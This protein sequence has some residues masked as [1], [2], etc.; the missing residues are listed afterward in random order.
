MNKDPA[1]LSNVLMLDAEGK[2]VLFSC[3]EMVLDKP[4][5]SNSEF[6]LALY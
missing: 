5:S 1:T 6:S 3:E 2:L 4:S